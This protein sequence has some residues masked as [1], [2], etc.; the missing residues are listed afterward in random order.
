[1]P[2]I[3]PRTSVSV[4]RNSDHRGGQYSV[5]DSEILDTNEIMILMIKVKEGHL[6]LFH[7]AIQV[8]VCDI[9]SSAG[10]LYLP[11]RGRRA[12]E[13]MLR[14]THAVLGRLELATEPRCVLKLLQTAIVR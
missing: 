3:E 2:G 9:T 8:S 6:E 7:D 4:A 13:H 12:V 5:K 10:S 1:V 14:V 11:P